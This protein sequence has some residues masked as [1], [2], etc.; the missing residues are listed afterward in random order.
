MAWDVP[1]TL[2]WP[3][4]AGRNLYTVSGPATIGNANGDILWRHG[5]LGT[6]G[7]RSYWRATVAP[8]GTVYT[9]GNEHVLAG[10][11]TFVYAS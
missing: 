5:G 4:V 6:L 8:D 10:G 7:G 9:L 2:A 1:T 3:L 11:G